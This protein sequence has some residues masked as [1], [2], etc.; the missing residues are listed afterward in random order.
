MRDNVN[1]ATVQNEGNGAHARDAIPEF[2]RSGDG[3]TSCGS[4]QDGNEA[5]TAGFVADTLDTPVLKSYSSVLSPNGAANVGGSDATYVATSVIPNGSPT[6]A[7]GLFVNPLNSEPVNFRSLLNEEKVESYDCVLLQGVADG[8]KNRYENT[9][10][11]NFLG[12]SLAFPIIQNYVNN[13]W[14]NF[15]LQKLMRTDDGKG[16]VTCVLV[17]VKLHGVP[18]LAYSGDG[19]SLIATQI[20]SELK[21]EVTMAIPNKEEDDRYTKEVIRTVCNDPSKVATKP[22]NIEDM[23]TVDM[24]SDGFKEGTN[25]RGV[26]TTAQVGANDINKANGPST[27]NSFDAL[28]NMD[29]W[30][31]CGVSS[32]RGIQEEDSEAG[33]KTSQRNE[34]HESDD[35]KFGDKFDIR[36]KGGVRK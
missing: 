32:S 3:Y 4:S 28:N 19:L 12:K 25:M 11:G 8:V 22:C 17:W 33:L 5:G 16:E 20:G 2:V 24:T 13:A 7:P 27:S 9:L 35:D 34:D 23:G 14:S 31:D 29:V 26:N 6:I 15:G 21:T 18:I 36:L 30:A 1:A 10:V